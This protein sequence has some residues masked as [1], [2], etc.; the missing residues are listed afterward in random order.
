MYLVSF[1][2]RSRI[3]VENSKFFIP[4]VFIAPIEAGPS[5][6]WQAIFEKTG[7]I[8]LPSDVKVSCFT[9]RTIVTDKRT[10]SSQLNVGAPAIHDNFNS[11]G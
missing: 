9:Q 10:E 6:Y 1:P 8:E 3:L 7:V 11:I 4:S 5:N 2:S